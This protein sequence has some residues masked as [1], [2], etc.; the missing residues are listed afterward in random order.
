M[1]EQA[2][3]RKKKW[4]E[5]IS[6]SGY[7]FGALALHLIVFIMVATWVIFPA[8]QP[9]T[10]DFTKTYLPPPSAPPP[11]PSSQETMP[12]P[13]QA[14]STPTTTITTPNPTASF[15]VPMPDITP[16]TT[17]VDMQQKMTQKVDS[18]PNTISVARLQ[19]IMSTEQGWGRDKSNIQESNSDPRNIK[20]TFPV[21]LA[22]YARGDWGCNTRMTDGRIEG[23]G[24][25]NLVAKINEWSHGN[26]T[27]TVMPTPLSIGGPDLLDKK[28][29]FIFFTGHRDFIL[30]DQE[31]Q[32]LRDYLQVGGCIWGD[33]ALAG[34][35]SRFDVAFRREMKRVVPDVDKNF[36][37]VDVTSDVFTKSWFPIAQV[38]E[39]M[40]YYAEPLEH[41]DIDGKLAIFYTPNDY[42]DMFTM[43][44]LPGD[45]A[46]G[47]IFS[48]KKN[49]T[50][51][52]TWRVF[53]EK[54]VIFFRN[55]ELPSCL[56]CDQMGMN[57]IGY[58]LVRFDKDLLL[59]P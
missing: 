13:T 53:L 40:N 50:N 17:P 8:F 28:P 1:A 35:G 30:T 21:Y 12:V 2:E 9:P 25:V 58:L 10:E 26:I 16:A 52:L 7:F 34:R 59:T 5:K 56:A 24:L 14:V 55:Y 51:L 11:P 45:T 41:L 49:P 47:P 42:S 23:G 6:R 18:K 54:H 36:E 4:F 48:T 32:N 37:P 43:S 15:T 27:G 20:A 38:P 39:G 31:I 19:Q 29:P 57:I 3:D 44:I 46:M 33:N 22:S